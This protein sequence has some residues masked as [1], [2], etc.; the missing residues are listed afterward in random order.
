MKFDIVGIPPELEP[1]VYNIQVDRIL[2]PRPGESEMRVKAH[3]IAPV[4][5]LSFIR[6]AMAEGELDN[7]DFMTII[8]SLGLA[9]H[10]EMVKTNKGLTGIDQSIRYLSEK[11]IQPFWQKSA[12]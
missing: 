6:A 10:D 1:G 9:I 5:Q 2:L 11:R 7:I 8:T 3:F 4:D 12:D